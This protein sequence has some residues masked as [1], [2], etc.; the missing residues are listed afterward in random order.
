MDTLFVT[1]VVD[2]ICIAKTVH[3]EGI[4]NRDWRCGGIWERMG[5]RVPK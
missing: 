3:G 4:L 5:C 1:E 2:I